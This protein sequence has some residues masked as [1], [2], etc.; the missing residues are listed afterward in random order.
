MYTELSF[1][2]C[3]GW[4]LVG[5]VEPEEKEDGVFVLKDEDGEERE[6][7]SRN[8]DGLLENEEGDTL[9]VP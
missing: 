3:N 4:R 7:S 9:L 8:D 1:D 5:Q 6:F 2:G